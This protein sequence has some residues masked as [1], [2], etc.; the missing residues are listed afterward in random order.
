MGYTNVP[1][2]HPVTL[3]K[4][5]A[6]GY[7][8][9]DNPT[10]GFC[11]FTNQSAEVHIMRKLRCLALVL[12]LLTSIFAFGQKQDWLP[13][14]PQDQ[15]IKDVPGDPGAGAVQLYYRDDIDHNLQ[16]ELFYHRIKILNDSGKKYADVEI[17]AGAGLT[18]ND[19]KARTIHPDGSI[20]EF[21]GK[22]FEKTVFKTRGV[23]LVYK[24][25]TMPDV[26]V[27]S[28]IEYKYRLEWRGLVF[29]DSWIL[30]HDLYTVKEDFSFKP[31]T[32]GIGN[33][34]SF[35][36][37]SS[38]SWV[39]VNLKDKQPQ[40]KGGGVELKMEKV[41]A[42]QSEDYMPPEDNFKPAV[43]FYYTAENY[44]SADKFWQDVG[45]EVYDIIEHYIG[46]HK[47]VREAAL[48][49]IGNETDP[50]KKLRRIYAR[51]QQIRNLSFERERSKEELK[52]EKIKENEGISEVL[53]RGYGDSDDITRLFVG[54]ARAAGFD[55]SVLLVS[56]R[57]K[58]F[59]SKELTSFRS[60]DSEIADVKLNG[61]DVYLEPGTQFCPYGQL[62]WMHTSTP[63]LRPDKKN[64]STFINVPPAPY[65]LSETDR[66][67]KMSVTEDGTAK[68]EITVEFKGQEA[69][70]HRLD[71]RDR[72]EAGRK[73]DLEDELKEWLPAGA[74]VKL[75]DSQGWTAV[76]EPLLA[77]FTVEIP[78]YA[79]MAGKRF[80][81]PSYLFQLKQ[82]SAFK[83]ADRKYPV[84]FAYAFSE[85][86]SVTIK[87]PPGY[88]T[89]SVPQ[90]QSAGIAA[91]QYQ[92]VS[93]FDGTQLK[94]E[95]S[96][97]F[98]GIYF[99]LT[100]YAEIKDFFTKV[101]AGDEQQAVLRM[102]GTNAQKN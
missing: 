101:Q 26:T 84:Y 45:N 66:T 57:R 78:S 21:T 31:F 34:F 97:L 42:F 8:L 3:A 83:H 47:E 2:C 100:R 20:V 94:T 82:V 1:Q 64:S 51:A 46:N 79:S 77:R 23:K 33:Q 74:I 16:Y 52:K 17:L 9:R 13:I 90:P 69:L 36:G 59:F 72:D 93:Q 4:T 60:L 58:V 81:M 22:P 48:E 75:A 49:A 19:L 70:E 67:A 65:N 99:P 87:L 76:E 25:F 29:S 30:Q 56:N 38:V 62:R 86:D 6:L 43:Y 55:A 7:I 96:L 44:K 40:R 68:G 92:N 41:P 10:P 5:A 54:M 32:G 61:N 37:G 89:E 98:N 14:T 73:K 39:I 35:F 53:K 28:I 71:A 95:R 80:L 91:A 18:V 88:S 63:A 27:G 85:R 15:Q 102:G 11:P 12:S 24:A 50:E